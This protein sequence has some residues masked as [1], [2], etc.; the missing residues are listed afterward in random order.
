MTNKRYLLKE[1]SK[2]VYQYTRR[3]IIKWQF[4]YRQKLYIF[5]FFLEQ[6]LNAAWVVE[7][8]VCDIFIKHLQTNKQQANATKRNTTLDLSYLYFYINVCII[9]NI[10]YQS[11]N[12][13]YI[14]FSVSK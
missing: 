5:L 2:Y 4:V 13:R 11:S 1:K 8:N 12:Q 14:Y 9:R 3:Q 10:T 6:Y 7:I